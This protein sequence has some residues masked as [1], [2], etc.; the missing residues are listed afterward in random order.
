M[1]KFQAKFQKIMLDNQR[2]SSKLTTA[3]DIASKILKR[4][5]QWSDST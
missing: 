2:Q 3:S 5:S 4:Y 1:L